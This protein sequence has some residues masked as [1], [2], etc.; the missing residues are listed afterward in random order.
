MLPSKIGEL[1]CLNLSGLSGP[2]FFYGGKMRFTRSYLIILLE[3]ILLSLSGCAS[4]QD[5]LNPS[6]ADKDASVEW[7]KD[8][9][10]EVNG[11][12][13]RGIATVPPAEVYTIKIYPPDDRIDRLQWRTCHRED[14]SDKA[15][16]YG[17]WPWSKKQKYFEMQI[18]PRP[19]EL[20]RSCPLMLEALA[21]KHKEMGFGMVIW[22][23]SR[24][25]FT[26]NSTIECNGIRKIRKGTGECQGPVGSIH[27]IYFSEKVYTDDR[28]N[29]K[30]PPMRRVS[31]NVY[32]FFMPKDVCVYPF[33]SA[34]KHDNGK[35][36]SYKILT[37]GYEKIPPPKGD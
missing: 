13:Y 12:A 9:L 15:V 16:K 34:R 35:R 4:I 5:F 31:D 20:E 22:P 10:L 2:L 28:A 11:K 33:L 19:I 17:S 6:T 1:C 23:D 24:P 21:Q 8:I 32:E 14:F 29:E 27:K 3:V 26:L 30:C 7:R 36:I 37:Y 25:E 18:A